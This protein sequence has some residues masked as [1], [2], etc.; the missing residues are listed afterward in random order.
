MATFVLPFSDSQATLERVGGKGLSLARLAQAGLPVP[1]GFHIT[2]EAYRQFIAANDLQPRILAAL[3]AADPA[4][5]AALEAAS[6][7][8]RSL[9]EAGKIP[10]TIT[11]EIRAAYAGMETPT[12]QPPP[13][14]GGGGILSGFW[15]R[16]GAK[17]HL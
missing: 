5:P 8:I 10:G 17:T 11:A 1:G 4:D 14:V 3:Q 9:F 12:P 16:F 6:A 15:R 2:T 7:Q 13:S